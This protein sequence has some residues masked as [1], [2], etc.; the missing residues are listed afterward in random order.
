M[1]RFNVKE[2]GKRNIVS[3]LVKRFGGSN[4]FIKEKKRIRFY[5]YN[6]YNKVDESFE[7]AGPREKIY[8][9]PNNAR[10]AIVTCGGISP[11]LNDVIRSIVMEAHYG[12]GISSILGIK[13]GYNGLIPDNNFKMITLNPENVTDIHHFGGT[14][15]GSSRG[16]TSDISVL[17][18][19]IIKNNINILFTIGGDGTQKGAHAIYLEA[20][21]RNYKLSVIG[22]PKTIDNDIAFI[23]RTFGFDTAFSIAVK[24]IMT[25]NVEATSAPNGIGLV[26]LMGRDSGFIAANAALG[27]ND[28]NYLIIPEVKF[29]LEKFLSWLE[30][31]INSRRHAVICVAEGAGQEELRK[32][33]ELKY[34]A[35]G[36]PVLEDIGLFL[37]NKIKEFFKEKNI[38]IN[39]KYIDPSYMIRTE[40]ANANDSVYCITLGQHAVHAAM[41]GKTDMLVGRWSNQYTHVPIELATSKKKRINT[42]SPFWYR[43]ME[44]TGQPLL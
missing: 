39:L 28:V 16:G 26:K 7:L 12:Y 25:A 3:P 13:F 15:L 43:V 32:D 20:E 5:A 29:D 21:K 18:D 2:L 8:F 1:N 31:R 27:M 40:P 14:I 11:G 17:V 36:N 37:K 42:T 38:P 30:D 33:K 6:D 41:A 19:T 4:F 23:Q 9:S 44:A 10:P 35:S 22:I 34:D 24:S